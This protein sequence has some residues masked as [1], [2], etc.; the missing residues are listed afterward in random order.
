MHI[1]IGE[2]IGVWSSEK[3]FGNLESHQHINGKGQISSHRERWG[4]KM[5]KAFR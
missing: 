4:L 1:D 3:R 2:D 5:E